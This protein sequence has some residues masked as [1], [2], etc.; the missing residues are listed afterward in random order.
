MAYKRGAI[1]IKIQ[2]FQLKVRR[3]SVLR[4]HIILKFITLIKN[5]ISVDE[6][7][8]FENTILVKIYFYLFLI[9]LY[10]YTNIIKQYL[11]TFQAVCFRIIL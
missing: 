10:P 11:N 8:G 1:S 7:R 4:S 5:I 6:V 3:K 2:A 9:F